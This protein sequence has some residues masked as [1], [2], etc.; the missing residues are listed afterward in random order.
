MLLTPDETRRLFAVARERRFAVLAINADSPS[1][2]GD[3]LEAARA[4]DAPLLIETSLWQLTGRSFGLGD[5][6]LG[7][8]R[9][10]AELSA[11]AVSERYAAVPVAFHTDHIKGPETLPLLT[12]AIAGLPLTHHEH[13]IELRPSSVSLDSSQLSEAEN[14]THAEALCAAADAAGYRLCLELEAGVDDGVTELAVTERIVDGIERTHPGQL[15]LWAPGLGSRHGFTDEGFPA[16]SPAAVAEHVA[17]A[18][19]IT[20]RPM[21]IALHG[22]S[23]LPIDAMQQAVA[24]GVVKVNWSSESLLLRGQ[25]ARAYYREHGERI[26]PGAEGFKA[27]AMDNG[28]ASFVAERY[29]PVV[30]QRI[31][32]LGAAGHATAVRDALLAGTA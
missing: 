20:G 1:A 13:R 27:A 32:Q 17:C 26:E 14:L 23:G 28:V 15:C 5:A 12:A 8:T 2:I 10:L 16:F 4:S 6:V 29:V 18:E 24:N 11:L 30:C 3:A 31:E 21:G 19:A 7:M 9:Y 22:S 25:A